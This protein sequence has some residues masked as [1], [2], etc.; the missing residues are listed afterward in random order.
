VIK[1][2]SQRLSRNPSNA[3]YSNPLKTYSI[4]ATDN[5]DGTINVPVQPVQLVD[6]TV[7]PIPMIGTGGARLPTVVYGAGNGGT[8]A[9]GADTL[10]MLSTTF[11]ADGSGRQGIVT[12][13]TQMVGNI[14]SAQVEVQRTPGIYR[15]ALC[16]T[17][18]ATV[19]WDP[20]A[21]KKFRLMGYVI[22]PS[23]GMAAAG[24]Q[25][26]TLLDEAAAITI[27]H[28]VYLPIAASVTNQAPIVVQLPANGYLSVAADN[29]LSVT[30]T[31]ACTAGA[32]SVMVYGT[33]E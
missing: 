13:A 8:G 21:G 24:I 31:A 4:P 15:H 26:I 14:L 19:V 27:A 7:E 33:E 9:A 20:A 12:Y 23:A 30:L 2:P 5:P 10:P 1:T 11:S 17:V 32:I 6:A 16:T 28:Q 18:A 3:G 25:L 22:I 29:R